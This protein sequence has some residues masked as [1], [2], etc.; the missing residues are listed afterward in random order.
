MNLSYTTIRHKYND[1][2]EKMKLDAPAKETNRK[3]QRSF[4]AEQLIQKAFQEKIF[5]NTG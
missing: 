3:Y 4:E 1:Y 5:K 2:K